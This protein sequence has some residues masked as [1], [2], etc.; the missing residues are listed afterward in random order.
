MKNSEAIVASLRAA[1][2][3]RARKKL[4]IQACTER[5]KLISAIHSRLLEKEAQSGAGFLDLEAQ[6]T[7]EELAVLLNPTKSL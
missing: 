3:V 6:L 7:A 1:N 5:V 2:S 4:Y